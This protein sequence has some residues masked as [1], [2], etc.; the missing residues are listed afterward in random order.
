MLGSELTETPSRK[1]TIWFKTADAAATAISVQDGRAFQGHNMEV[2]EDGKCPTEDEFLSEHP[3]GYPCAP[4]PF[5]Q[6][7]ADAP[8]SCIATASGDAQCCPSGGFE[9][10]RTLAGSASPVE[11]VQTCGPETCAALKKE[12]GKLVAAQANAILFCILSGVAFITLNVQK[13]KG[14]QDGDET[15]CSMVLAIVL[16]LALICAGAAVGIFLGSAKDMLPPGGGLGGGFGCF[17]AA[18]ILEVANVVVV[19]Q[20]DLCATNCFVLFLRRFIASWQDKALSVKI[21]SAELFFLDRTCRISQPRCSFPAECSAMLRQVGQ[22]H[23]G[24]RGPGEHAGRRLREQDHAF[25]ETKSKTASKPASRDRGDRHP[26]RFRAEDPGRLRGPA[27]GHARHC[28]R[29]PRHHVPR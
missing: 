23:E 18:W 16:I 20:S 19:F 13:H 4:G 29:V 22:T 2:R 12:Q 5:Y 14:D 27:L 26:P 11:N 21:D 15:N 24:L 25:Q 1:A 8:P 28:G 10:Y 6:A 7:D 17:I 9:F 3:E